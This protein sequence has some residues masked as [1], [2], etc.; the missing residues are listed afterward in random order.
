MDKTFFSRNRQPL[1]QACEYA[2]LIFSCPSFTYSEAKQAISDIHQRIGSEIHPKQ[3]K[4][5]LDSLVDKGDVRFK[6]VNRWRR[7]W[8]VT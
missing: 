3:V 6:G 2:Y 1:L 4:R 5:T 7:Y 8:A